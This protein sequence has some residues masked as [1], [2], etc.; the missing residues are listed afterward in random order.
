MCWQVNK[1]WNELIKKEIWKSPAKRK[2][3]EKKLVNR[4]KTENPTAVELGQ[5]RERVTNIFCNDR[6][7]FCGQDNGIV[8]VYQSYDGQWVRDLVP[9]EMMWGIKLLAG[10][11]GVLAA[12]SRDVVLTVW[13]TTDQTKE[14]HCFNAH[15]YKCLDVSC[16][17]GADS[18][19]G[20]MKVIDPAKIAVL[21]EHHD[22]NK[23]S[24]LFLKRIEHV[25]VE[26]TLA[27]FPLSMGDTV[28]AA[29]GDLVA[30]AIEWRLRARRR[31]NVQRRFMMWQENKNTGQE[32]ELPGRGGREVLAIFMELPFLVLIL[33]R[34]RRTAEVQVYRMGPEDPMKDVSSEATIVYTICINNSETDEGMELVSNRLFLGVVHKV[35]GSQDWILNLYEK[36]FLFNN[37]RPTEVSRRIRLPRSYLGNSP[38]VTL[39]NSSLIIV[40]GERDEQRRGRRKDFL[41][42]KDFWTTNNVL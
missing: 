7:I 18:T 39:T 41:R 35:W 21:V 6:H 17:H 40:W 9:S 19:I 3:L 26:E 10:S 37:K 29:D 32:I 22:Q 1:E 15:N 16:D 13:S 27:C 34:D 30:V 28:L 2:E 11:V 14:L 24:L 25:W 4:W 5:A 38:R 33:G 23:A 12:V 8:G 31:E 36:R 42:K 20:Q